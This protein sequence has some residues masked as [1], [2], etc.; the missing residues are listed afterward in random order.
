GG[1]S[2]SAARWGR[3]APTRR[4]LRSTSAC[5][6]HDVERLHEHL[7][8]RD[9]LAREPGRDVDYRGRELG[10]EP[11]LAAERCQRPTERAD[12]CGVLRFLHFSLLAERTVRIHR[13]ST[14]DPTMMYSCAPASRG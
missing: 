10:R 11:L 2:R 13:N 7:A 1:G 14:K 6:S 3:C 8:R 12:R 5:S 4:C 9:A